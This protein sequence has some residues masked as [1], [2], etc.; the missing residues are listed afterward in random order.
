MCALSIGTNPTFTSDGGSGLS[1]E[2][3]L[4]DFDADLYGRRL[5]L[6]I[7]HRL[8]DEQR[9]ESAAALVARIHEDLRETRKVMAR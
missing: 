6:E 9:F 3:H 4:L 8:R 1:I 5:R 7:V 2:A